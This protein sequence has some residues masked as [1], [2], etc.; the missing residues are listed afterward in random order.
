[1]S[2]INNKYKFI[3]VHVPKNGG[4][5]ITNFL[6]SYSTALDIEIGGTQIGE[7]LQTSYIERYG[8]SK[9]STSLNLKKKSR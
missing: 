8:I 6:S 9:H 4:T 3:F 7:L 5:S 1:M 2:I